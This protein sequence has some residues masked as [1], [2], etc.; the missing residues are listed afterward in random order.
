MNRVHKYLFVFF[1]F[2]VISGTAHSSSSSKKIYSFNYTYATLGSLNHH[3]PVAPLPKL[4]VFRYHNGIDGNQVN[5]SCSSL[6]VIY[7]R[8]CNILLTK[9][10]YT[11]HYSKAVSYRLPPSPSLFAAALLRA[12]PFT[13]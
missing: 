9:D 3:C 8:L 12:P 5:V 1:A 6:P 13:S 7:V 2:L 11:Q 4:A 10:T